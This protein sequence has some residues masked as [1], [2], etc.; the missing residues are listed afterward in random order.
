M[1]L[2]INIPDEMY[3]ILIKNYKTLGLCCS[4]GNG[5]NLT[6]VIYHAVAN[7]T[8]LP[9]NHGDL[10]DKD[11][12]DEEWVCTYNGEYECVKDCPCSECIYSEYQYYTDIR[13]LPVI[14]KANKTEADLITR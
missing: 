7:G 8:P 2:V 4:R 3:E 6:S 13:D 5:K 14:I 10:V 1:E 12:T 9:K 11:D